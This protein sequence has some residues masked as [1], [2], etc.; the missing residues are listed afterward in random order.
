M[1]LNRRYLPHALSL[2]YTLGH[3]TFIVDLDFQFFV[4]GQSRDD[5][6]CLFIAHTCMI[7]NISIVS[8]HRKVR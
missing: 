2:E 1:I 5:V 7:Y 4:Q 3:K 6:R 8:I